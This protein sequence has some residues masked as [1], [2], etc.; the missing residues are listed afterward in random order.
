[1][2][3]S[4][5]SFMHYLDVYG[6]PNSIQEGSNVEIYSYIIDEDFYWY[7]EPSVNGYY[8]IKNSVGDF[9]LDVQEA[10]TING[11]NVQLWSC[12]YN[13]NAQNWKIETTR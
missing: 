11:T 12:S 6:S 9:C 10:G 4:S 7:V 3:E 1:M 8:N 13:N 2:L 5:V